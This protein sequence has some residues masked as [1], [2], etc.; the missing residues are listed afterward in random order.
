LDEFFENTNISLD[1]TIVPFLEKKWIAEKG[2]FPLEN[3][4]TRE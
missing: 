2:T 3:V 4:V 1:R